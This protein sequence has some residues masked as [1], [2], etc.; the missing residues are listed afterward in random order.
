MPI[1]SLVVILLVIGALVGIRLVLFK[2]FKSSVEL[3]SLPVEN[4]VPPTEVVS[5][6]SIW[7]VVV[8][9]CVVAGLIV[10]LM[11]WGNAIGG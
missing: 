11:A 3:P 4:V 1:S 8:L 7:P 2:M 9:L 6:T 10:G 5:Q